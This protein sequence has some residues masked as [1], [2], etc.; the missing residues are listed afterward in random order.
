MGPVRVLFVEDEGLIRLITEEYLNENGFE[1]IEAWNGEE[2]VKL[3]DSNRCFDV[4]F[5]DVRMP[6]NV[7]GF[8]L[9]E[10]ARHRYPRLPVLIVSGYAE[11]LTGRL[12]LL[13]PPPVFLSKPYDLSDVAHTLRTMAA[14]A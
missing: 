10:H 8:A 2:A 5:T 7:D 6:G 13:D 4:L 1:V 3:L 9:A 14:E 11:N 12:R